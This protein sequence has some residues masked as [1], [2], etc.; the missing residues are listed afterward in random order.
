MGVELE[1]KLQNYIFSPKEEGRKQARL[2]LAG[3]T[4]GND[5]WRI[6]HNHGEGPSVMIFMPASQFY[7]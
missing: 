3:S 5:G 4:A 1:T 7:V 2:M 6:F